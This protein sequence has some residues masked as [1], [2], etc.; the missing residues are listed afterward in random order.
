MKKVISL[1]L[2]AV[3]LFSMILT[4]AFPSVALASANISFETKKFDTA[5]GNY[6]VIN[7]ANAGDTIYIVASLSHIDSFGGITLN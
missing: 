6:S 2:S 4:A 7:Q 5:A 3:L 1:L